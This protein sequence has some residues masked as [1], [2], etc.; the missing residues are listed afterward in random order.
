MNFGKLFGGLILSLAMGFSVAANTP[1]ERL[2]ELKIELPNTAKPVANYVPVVRSG[3]LIFLA[4]HIP[5]DEAGNF[6]TGKV[7]TDI[8]LAQAQHAAERT[9][10]ALLATLRGEIGSLNHVK[11]IVRVEGFVNCR[12]DF[13]NQSK[14]INGCSD[15]LVDIFGEKGRHTRLAIGAGSLPLNVSVE[16]A[17]IVEVE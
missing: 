10:L 7:G 3:N 13:T 8:T 9:A 5:K 16:I 1:E 12:G 6:I 14:V 2:T 17:M 4:G 11:R 15:L